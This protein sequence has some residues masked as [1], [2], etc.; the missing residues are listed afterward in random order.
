MSR[1]GSARRLAPYR[2]SARF[3]AR[4]V[5]RKWRHRL[6]PPS[7]RAR[8]PRGLPGLWTR[9]RR[10]IW[11]WWPWGVAAV[12]ALAADAWQWSAFFGVMAFVTYWSSPRERPPTYGLD[13]VIP[14]KDPAFLD[15]VV[16][17]T[18]ITFL[19]GNRVDL[20]NN[21]D[22][23]Y[24]SMLRAI[25]EAR[26]SVTIEAYIYWAGSVGKQFADAL[27]SRA[28][29]G[30]TV[31]IMLDA[32]GSSTIGTEILETLEAGGCQLAWF[33]PIKWYSISHFNYRTHRKSLIVDGRIGFTGGAGIADHWVGHAQDPAHWRDMQIRIEGPGVLPLQ[34]GFARNWQQTTGELVSG[35]DYFPPHEPAGRVPLHTVLSSPSTGASA[36][37]TLYYFAI[38]CAQ[39]SIHIAN[40][41][42]VPDQAAID[43]LVDAARRGVRVTIIVSGRH[44]DNFIARRNSVR[45]FGDLLRAGVEIFEYSRTMLH[46]KT[47]VV[48]GEWGTIGTTN[49]DNRSFAFNEESNVSFVDRRLVGD[50]E[51]AFERDRDVSN[52]LTFDAWRHRGVWARAQE[53]LVWLLQ[54]QV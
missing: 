8:R 6:E 15:S 9:I 50:L 27:A 14:T 28:R 37:R 38:V 12:W 44:N 39:R 7:A 49:F 47:M 10:M 16:G 19:E 5:P 36:A 22:E 24:P 46:H 1:F 21:G 42:F 3:R 53:A 41:Y 45:L 51:E 2:Y 52:Q 4:R 31:K 11:A 17:L 26:F 54:D 20:L 40:P 43:A 33:N 35:P 23:F 29:A 25:D 32:V 48:D 13:H 18:G 30:V 34:T